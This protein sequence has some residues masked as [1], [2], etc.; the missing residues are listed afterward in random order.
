M[1]TFGKNL[2]KADFERKEFLALQVKLFYD[3]KHKY[4]SI[5][6]NV[7]VH[8]SKINKFNNLTYNLFY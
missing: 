6:K 5:Y 7:K 4:Y 1:R 8:V 3:N 2:Y